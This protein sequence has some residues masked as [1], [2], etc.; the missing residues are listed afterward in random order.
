MAIVTISGSPF[1]HDLSKSALK[2]ARQKI[3]FARA[4]TEHLASTLRW[5][6]KVEDPGAIAAATD[7]FLHSPDVTLACALV[8]NSRMKELVPVV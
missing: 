6:V 8:A 4:A 7:A 2:E 5:A 1:K 3:E